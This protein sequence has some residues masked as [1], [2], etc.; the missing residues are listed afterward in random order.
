[1]VVLDVNEGDAL[2]NYLHHELF[3]LL[4]NKLE[5]DSMLREGAIYSEDA[6]M[7]LNPEGFEYADSTFVLPD[8]LYN[9]EYDLW[10]IDMYSRTFAREDRARIMEYAMLGD[11]NMFISAPYRQAKLEYLNQCIRDA[12]DTTGWPEVTVWEETLENSY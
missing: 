10:F 11:F 12:F 3:H 7:K 4:D 2:R 9:E 1:M 6:W 8:E 5:F